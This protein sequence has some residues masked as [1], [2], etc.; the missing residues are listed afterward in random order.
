MG[1]SMVDAIHENVD[2][3][4]VSNALYEMMVE[5]FSYV[6]MQNAGTTKSQKRKWDEKRRWTETA[7]GRFLNKSTLEMRELLEEHYG[8]KVTHD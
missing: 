5:W 7:I 6:A 3:T 2:P 1:K 8:V 4:T